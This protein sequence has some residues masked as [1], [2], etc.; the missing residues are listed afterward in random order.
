MH[1][2]K[3]EPEFSPRDEHER[4]MRQVAENIAAVAS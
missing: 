2:T 1:T 3:D 4:M